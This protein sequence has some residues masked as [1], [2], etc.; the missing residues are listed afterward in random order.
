[1]VKVS[2]AATTNPGWHPR[3]LPALGM[4]LALATLLVLGTATAQP[5][6]E[7]PMLAEL[8]AAGELPPVEERLPDNPEV[9]AVDQEIGEYGGVLRRGFTGPGDHNNY[10]RL[11]Y[12][13]LLRFSVDGSEMMP[14]ILESWE[15]S[16]DFHTWTLRLRPGAKARRPG[17][18]VVRRFPRLEDVRHHLA[19]V[20]TEAQQAVVDEA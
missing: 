16:D 4:V 5:Y 1:M 19:A 2:T 17:S 10:T 14:H 13:S 15:A 12:D 3:S 7:A 20:D 18:E 9:V 6:Q 8:V 11:V